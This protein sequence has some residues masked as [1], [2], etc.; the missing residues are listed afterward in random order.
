MVSMPDL[1]LDVAVPMSISDAAKR[2][3]TSVPD[4]NYRLFVAVALAVIGGPLTLFAGYLL[5]VAG[6]FV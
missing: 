6:Q 2:V 3:R 4:L 1:E 5:V